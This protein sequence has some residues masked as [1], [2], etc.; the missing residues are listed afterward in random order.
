MAIDDYR[1]SGVKY[2]ETGRGIN[3]IAN[4]QYAY[5]YIGTLFDVSEK[6]VAN[7]EFVNERV[8]T[9]FLEDAVKAGF[10]N[11]DENFTI[12]EFARSL[13]AQHEAKL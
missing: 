1:I 10:K 5:M 2:S 9:A 4:L 7:V 3:A 13:L 6:I 11:S 8:R 12:S